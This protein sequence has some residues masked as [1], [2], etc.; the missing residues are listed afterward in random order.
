MIRLAR[1]KELLTA[2]YV[3]T[4]EEAEAMARAGADVLVPHM[5]LTT[6]RHDRGGDGD[7]TRRL[8][9]TRSRRWPTRPGA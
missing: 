5:G 4:V 3:F 9:C 7:D 1:Q 2:P 6:E 8:A